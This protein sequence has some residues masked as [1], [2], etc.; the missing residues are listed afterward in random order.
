VNALAALKNR[1]QLMLGRCVLRAIDDEK[2]MQ[3]VEVGTLSGAV[4]GKVEHFHPYG[5]SSKPLPGAEGVVGFVG[6]AQ[7]HP[8]LLVVADRRYRFQPL[9][10]G[11]CALHSQFGDFV[12][13][14][15]ADREIEVHAA[16]KVILSAPDVEV[17]G[18]F[19]VTGTSQFDA[20]INCDAS[21]VGNEVRS[22]SADL[23]MSQVKNFYNAHVHPGGG[24]PNPQM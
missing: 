13:L 8:I 9:Q 1:M 15:P 14:R 4:R 22:V 7:D 3:L 17:V 23:N 20:Q 11:G 18:R 2:K 19:K 10:D 24:A 12:V 21:I 5:F 6:G 16:T